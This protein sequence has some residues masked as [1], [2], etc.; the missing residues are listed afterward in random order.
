MAS[1]TVTARY[2]SSYGNIRL[3]LAQSP[4]ESRVGVLVDVA[5]FLRRT[6]GF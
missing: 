5:T 1:Q 2:R 6:L 4:E 3:Q